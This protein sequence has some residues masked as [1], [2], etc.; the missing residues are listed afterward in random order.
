MLLARLLC[1]LVACDGVSSEPL[2]SKQRDGN[3]A[4]EDAA[5]N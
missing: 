4:Y 3:G 5:K 1:L 2:E